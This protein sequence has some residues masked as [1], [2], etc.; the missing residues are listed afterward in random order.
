[1]AALQVIECS[2]C[3]IARPGFE[4]E[5]GRHCFCQKGM[6]LVALVANAPATK[7]RPPQAAAA[8]AEKGNATPGPWMATV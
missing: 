3:E 2:V 8:K 1:M 6:Q 4:Q 5:A 7:K